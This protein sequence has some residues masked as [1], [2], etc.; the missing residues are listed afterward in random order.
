VVG[1][2]CSST[3]GRR[4]LMVTLDD[5]LVRGKETCEEVGQRPAVT[6]MWTAF[7]SLRLR[8]WLRSEEF[9]GSLKQ[10]YY[11][12][13]H[14]L[15]GH[16][17]RKLWSLLLQRDEGESSSSYYSCSRREGGTYPRLPSCIQESSISLQGHLD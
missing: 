13:S 8:L 5:V 10:T 11:S 9:R 14:T 1:R 16:E 12:F 4:W 7:V 2:I 15:Q 6:R 17:L 3:S